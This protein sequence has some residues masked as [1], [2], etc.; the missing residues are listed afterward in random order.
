MTVV[1]PPPGV[2]HDD[3]SQTQ[4][5]AGLLELLQDQLLLPVVAE[6]VGVEDVAVV[7]RRQV[8]DVDLSGL[9][10]RKRRRRRS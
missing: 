6:L 9:W 5:G 3:W 8:V 4:K 1:P 10:G 2:L 7:E